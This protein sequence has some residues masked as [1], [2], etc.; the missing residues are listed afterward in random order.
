MA[1]L[2]ARP[3]QAG[4]KQRCPRCQ[5]Q[6][7]V[8]TEEQAA[9]L[10][11]RPE[12]YPIFEGDYQAQLDP[13]RA[14]E[15]AAVADC[16]ACGTRVY[17]PED[18]IGRQ[19]ECPDCGTMVLVAAR[20]LAPGE[21][22]LSPGEMEAYALLDE[23][24]ESQSPSPE[25]ASPEIASPAD[26]VHIPVYCP[27]CNTLL[28][29]TLDDVGKH[30]LC[31]D[32]Y[33]PVLV[34]P[35][36]EPAEAQQPATHP[37]EDEYALRAEA[38]DR[39]AASQPEDEPALIPV[40]CR[41]CQTRMYGTVDQVGE[42]ITCPD[43]GTPAVV[44]RPEAPR[45]K[46]ARRA[47]AAGE[48]GVGAPAERERYE[49]RVDVRLMRIEPGDTRSVEE[50]GTAGVVHVR[51]PPPDRPF[52][53]GII[54]FLWH[55][56]TWPRLVGLIFGL[57][58]V[59]PVL[60]FALALLGVPN[61][62]LGMALPWIAA[63]IFFAAAM[64]FVFIWGVVAAAFLLAILQDTAEGNDEIEAWPEGMFTDWA[65]DFLYFFTALVASALPGVALLRLLS[66]TPLPSWMAVPASLFFFF[67]VVLLSMLANSS[68]LVPVSGPV[69]G[70][71]FSKWWA[72]AIFYLETAALAVA[73]LG[74][75]GVL[76]DWMGLWG[77]VPAA[78]VWV[79]ILMIYFR[80]LGRVAWCCAQGGEAV[81]DE[82]EARF[83]DRRP[84]TARPAPPAPAPPPQAVAS[85]PPPP[86]EAVPK[87]PP[88]QEAPPKPPPPRE[89]PPK[90]PPSQK[91]APSIL[92][93][94]FD[95]A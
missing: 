77:T 67:P 8:P 60:V 75:C 55:R 80:L 7:V 14:A 85:R 56:G 84:T 2:R 40:V 3:S 31:P 11:R 95:K 86:R 24:E 28:H 71:L 21:Q 59:L 64:V 88:P 51:P 47:T 22:S 37:V 10:A 15:T 9:W 83:D 38:P 23:F 63:M 58:L 39:A 62:G 26:E 32:C 13:A 74:F 46:P 16:R 19:V 79:P 12:A 61:L 54:G 5:I 20:P 66:G 93:D 91:P 53:R 65:L 33:S 68:P 73:F 44:P 43:C 78:L 25:S 82:D 50:I 76:L 89:A 90:P 52:S 29:G 42:L 36:Q 18:Q 94:D 57:L 35:P 34:P 81:A 49:P 1:R 27:V 41:L 69:W 87:P 30:L 48:Y 70:S 6:L 4:T 92:D 17:T 45:P 72:W